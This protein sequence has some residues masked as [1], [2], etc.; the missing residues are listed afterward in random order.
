MGEN[1]IDVQMER[2]ECL[3]GVVGDNENGGGSIR[4]RLQTRCVLL[5][6]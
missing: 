6:T 3:R 4:R 1:N 5:D 2:W